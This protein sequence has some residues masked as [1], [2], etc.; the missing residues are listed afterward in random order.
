VPTLSL[1]STITATT[2]LVSCAL[3]E[4]AVLLNVRTGTYY[5]LDAVGHRIWQ[6]VQQPR[7]V[8]SVRDVVL[9]EFDV[10]ADRCER[11]LLSL[12]VDLE[13]H[14]LIQVSDAVAR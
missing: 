9:D 2:D 5:G 1:Q 7:T 3:D 12:I 4:E 6:L 14:Q 13:R 10:A 8:E 11:E